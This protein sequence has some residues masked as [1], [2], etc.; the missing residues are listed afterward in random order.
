[1]LKS[2]S[3]PRIPVCVRF[4]PAS[5]TACPPMTAITP[6][7]KGLQKISVVSKIIMKSFFGLPFDAI[8][9]ILP[10]VGGILCFFVEI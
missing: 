1:M 8:R 5:R 9:T 10:L 7:S 4:I 2:A 6:A 3:N